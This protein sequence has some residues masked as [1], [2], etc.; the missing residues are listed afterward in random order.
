[1]DVPGPKDRLQPALLDRL[2][3]TEPARA[4]EPR[5]ARLITRA[6]LRE[7][8]LR[9]LAWLLN[10][11]RL[12]GPAEFGSFTEARRS[13]LNF[14]LPALAGLT[15]STLDMAAVE[16]GIRQAILDFEPRIRPAS[17]RVQA[18]GADTLLVQHNIVSIDIRGTLLAQPVPI[19]LLLR[20]EV[21]LETGVVE[22]RDVGSP[23]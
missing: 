14:G 8:V 1:M 4:Q 6:R 22:L 21:D 11:T 18:R 17:L 20:T 2:I 19:E 15:V 7:A 23:A 16:E 9:D 13:V 12:G 10:T 5:E 3:D